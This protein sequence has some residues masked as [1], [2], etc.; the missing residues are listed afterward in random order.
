MDQLK[1]TTHKT[2]ANPSGEHKIRANLE[3]SKKTD[4]EGLK[5]ESSVQKAEVIP[6]SVGSQQKSQISKNETQGPSE[7]ERSPEPEEKP[8]FSKTSL[9]AI[10]AGVLVLLTLAFLSH[11]I[12]QNEKQIGEAFE[13]VKETQTQMFSLQNTVSGHSDAIVSA[14]TDIQSFGGQLEELTVKLEHQKIL[15]WKSQLNLQATVLEELGKFQ[16]PDLQS[17]MNQV[18]DQLKNFS[19]RL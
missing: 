3:E 10:V 7:E 8:P 5:P 13:G 6:L 15:K 17:Q 19:S 14:Q 18:S 9:F 1:K 12:S 16:K 4:T 2:E 11:Q